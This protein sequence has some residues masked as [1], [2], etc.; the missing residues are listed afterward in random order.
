MQDFLL[1]HEAAVRLAVFGGMLGALAAWEIVAPWRRSQHSRLARWWTN[2][3]LSVVGTLL[4]RLFLPVAAMGVA[5]WCEAGGFGLFNHFNVS[6]VLSLPLSLLALDLLIY[7]QHFLFHHVPLLWRLHRVHHADPEIDV[8][9]GVRFHPVEIFVSMALKMAM[10]AALGAP[11]LAVLLFEIVLNAMAMFNHTNA[12][13][14]IR[15]ERL[16]RRI[17]VTPDMHRI[18]HSVRRDEHDANFGFNLSI[19]DRLFRT[20]LDRP[21]DGFREMRI[22]LDEYGGTGPLKLA[23]SLALPFLNNTRPSRGA[24]TIR[25]EKAP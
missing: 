13:L 1:G 9:T 24:P 21:R 2:L 25:Q 11:P 3:G 15:A 6:L 4:V 17:I 8:T 23:W 12:S 14:P 22:G 5:A 20:Y 19:W 10:V 16:L 18:H 7:A